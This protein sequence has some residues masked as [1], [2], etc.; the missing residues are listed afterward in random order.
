MFFRPKN[1]QIFRA[2]L[3]DFCWSGLELRRP[4]F[5]RLCLIFL[6]SCENVCVFYIC[7]GFSLPGW[8]PGD[9]RPFPNERARNSHLLGGPKTLIGQDLTHFYLTQ[10]LGL[11]LFK[12]P[13]IYARC[14]SKESPPEI[15]EGSFGSVLVTES[16]DPLSIDHIPSI[17][18][19]PFHH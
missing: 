12:R 15:R 11:H 14:W 7:S 1:C 6:T 9:P 13:A 19:W 18:W 2:G 10:S 5:D 8:L 17:R 4:T 16:I 3:A